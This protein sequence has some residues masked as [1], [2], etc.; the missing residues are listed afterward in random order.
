M[1]SPPLI[2]LLHALL[3]YEISPPPLQRVCLLQAVRSSPPPPL[4]NDP[5]IVP[6]PFASIQPPPPLR[7]SQSHGRVLLFFPSGALERIGMF[8]GALV[9]ARLSR[10]SP[11]LRNFSHEWWPFL[12]SVA[13]MV[14]VCF[15]RE[16]TSSA[17]FSPFFRLFP[18][19]FFPDPLPIC[20][21]E[22]D[23][24]LP[25]WVRFDLFR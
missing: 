15:L 18:T 14:M 7:I 16:I 11:F 10:R 22:G 6:G 5:L 12:I 9:R 17:V 2:L 21:R 23:D 13:V 1:P 25:S 19:F 3:F 8:S 20:A 4:A 24:L